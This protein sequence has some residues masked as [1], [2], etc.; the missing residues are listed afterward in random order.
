MVSTN[1]F[2]LNLNF[3][4][5]ELQGQKSK[6]QNFSKFVKQLLNFYFQ[7]H[8]F[9]QSK[10]RSFIRIIFNRFSKNF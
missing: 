8:I 9:Q 7:K 2:L 4:A 6:I 3:S 10:G 1:N 5:K